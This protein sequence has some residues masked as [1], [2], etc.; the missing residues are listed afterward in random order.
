MLKFLSWEEFWKDT[1]PVAR[2]QYQ[3]WHDMVEN[4]VS[5]RL[6]RLTRSDE[7]NICGLY[8]FL[9]RD[10]TKSLYYHWL[11]DEE[12]KWLASVLPVEEN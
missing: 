10:G 5:Y 2:L 11:N 7:G 1:S 12:K 8:Q 6:V 4:C 3:E 9:N